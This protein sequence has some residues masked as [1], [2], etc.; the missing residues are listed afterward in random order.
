MD[1]M[2]EQVSIVVDAL[3]NAGTEYGLNFLGAVAILIIGA[4]IAGKV[5]KA[6]LNGLGKL[7]NFDDTLKPFLANVAKYAVMIV[8]IIAVLNQ[9]GVQTASIIAVLGAAGLAIGLALQGTLAN[10]AAGVML[11]AL[12][13][14]KTGDVIDVNGELGKAIE[15]GLFATE[16][17][18]GDGVFKAIPNSAVWS[19]TITNFSKNKIRRVDVLASIAYSDDL[20]K[21]LP[22]LTTLITSDDRYKKDPEPQV[23]VAA[24]AASSVDIQMRGWVDSDDYW[25]VLW[26]TTKK[27]KLELERNGFSI[28][29]PQQDVYMHQVKAED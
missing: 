25:Q 3:I 2:E 11:L 26:D 12:R 10:V 13:P 14:F 8:V 20:E 17:K 15:I 22:L 7:K 16:L 28:P 29:F 27:V 1:N 4:W 21:A 18:T 23:F 24:M 19:G 5:K 6:V 9:F